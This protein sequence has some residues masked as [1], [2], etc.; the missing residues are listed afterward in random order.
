MIEVARHPIDLERVTEL[1]N[2]DR[3]EMQVSRDLFPTEPTATNLEGTI[4][5]LRWA[6]DRIGA[7]DPTATELVEAGHFVALGQAALF[8][9]AR[10][11]ERNTWNLL[12]RD[13]RLKGSPD[14]EDRKASKWREGFWLAWTTFDAEALAL[15][16]QVPIDVV[17]PWEAF[18]R[19]FVAVL[20]ALF[21]RDPRTGALLVQALELADPDKVTRT[22]PDWILD[23]VVP[24]FECL[25]ALAAGD[26]ENFGAA[27][28]RLLEL[29]R[30]HYARNDPRSDGSMSLVSEEALGLAAWART[31]GLDVEID[32][33]YMPRALFELEPPAVKACAA[34][35]TPF[36]D[37]CQG[38]GRATISGSRTLG[39]QAW[40]DLPRASCA[41]CGHR[42]PSEAS[43]CPVCCMV[44]S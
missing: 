6:I 41:R 15:L 33:P 42:F 32:S 4:R 23:G 38:C 30:Q 1:A 21:S 25:I 26:H 29:R 22:N 27:L 9:W 8:T 2:E 13:R 34:C 24:Q 44:R 18:D 35:L 43:T 37:E 7:T 36:S 12:G 39:F 17:E 20:Q 5:G 3:K 11:P 31:L 10:R 16:V 28:V 40:Y 19:P 14:Q